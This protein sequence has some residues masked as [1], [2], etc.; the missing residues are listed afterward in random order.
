M[1]QRRN[2][3]PLAAGILLVAA[4]L[5]LLLQRFYDFD[6]LWDKLLL[7]LVALLI[8]A[9]GCAKLYRHFSW[10]ADQLQKSPGRASLLGGLFWASVGL[11][12]LLD[13][14]DVLPFWGTF[15]LYWPLL[16]VLFGLGKVVDF[17]RLKG[18]MQ[19]RGGEVM[20][21]I[22]LALLGF[23]SSAASEAHWPL[24]GLDW[25]R[26]WD[27]RFPGSRGPSYNWTDSQSLE[28]SGLSGLQISN[29]YGDVVVE[30]GDR[31]AIEIELTKEVQER[32]ESSARTIAD[33]IELRTRREKGVLEIGTNRRDLSEHRFQTH[34]TIRVPRNLHVQAVNGY[35]DLQASNLAAGCKLENER[36]NLR[37]GLIT[38]D[39]TLDNRYDAVV[40]RQIEGK[41][42]ITNRRG[43]VLIEELKGDAE[44]ATD[45]K[46]VT[47][48]EV[49]GNLQVKNYHGT[50]RLSNIRGRVNIDALGSSIHL[51]RVEQQATVSNSYQNM[52]AVGLGGGLDLTT[53]HCRVQLTDVTGPVDIAP[54]RVQLTASGLRS[55]IKV[56]GGVGT[57]VSVS[58]VS[59]PVEIVTSMEP[60]R[61]EDFQ[62]P[63]RIQNQ[64]A[65]VW[66]LSEQPLSANLFAENNGGAITLTVPASSSFDLTALAEG[67]SI[68]SEFGHQSSRGQDEVL[69]TSVGAGGPE[70]NL[71]TKL[72]EI[73][74]HKI[75]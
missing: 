21:L 3:T 74:I 14:Q 44:V 69:R 35:G 8:L 16:L 34:L 26:D 7:Q 51:S 23:F 37:V 62:G 54:R 2:L 29:I 52:T 38:G 66:I 55:G 27:V 70:V 71:Q 5:F 45:R 47:A 43:S 63:V 40:A 17:Y 25:P 19:F 28:A 6:I 73:R 9:M 49:E 72:A 42:T 67:G 60:V 32:S 4:G 46:S 58:D 41:L 18:R 57:S 24:I 59:G 11:L 22:L 65:E 39:V 12:L 75:G 36:G 1:S 15:G 20:G 48:D 68:A 10:D 61:L 13:L 56:T 64:N 31:E 30:G 53:E 33:Q 50:V